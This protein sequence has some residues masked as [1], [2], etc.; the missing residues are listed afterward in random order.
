MSPGGTLQSQLGF[1]ARSV[2]IKNYTNQWVYEPSSGYYAEPYHTNIVIPLPGTQIA[3]LSFGLPPGL[4]QS[5]ASPKGIVLATWSSS[6]AAF[7]QGEAIQF[8]GTQP[9]SSGLLD[10]THPLNAPVLG[11]STAAMLFSGLTG[12]TFVFFAQ[13]SNDGVNWTFIDSFL[14]GQP[15]TRAD[16]VF[17]I[18]NNGIYIANVW[19]AAYF[20]VIQQ[21]TG[22]GQVSIFMLP[23]VLPFYDI[24]SDV[25]A[26]S[27][28]VVIASDQQSLP[29]HYSAGPSTSNVAGFVNAATVAGAWTNMGANFVLG[30][31]A[32]RGLYGLSYGFLNGA[33]AG[34]CGL[35]LQGGT[36]GTLYDLVTR[37]NSNGGNIGEDII[38][39]PA[40]DLIT[41]GFIN[42]E[43]IN[44]QYF[45][46]Q[47]NSTV[48]A[49]IELGSL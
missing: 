25:A 19:G 35:R 20:R 12:G 17:G 15:Y 8:E 9:V 4:A 48:W 5:T 47:A 38:Y 22:S 21:G 24:G 42:G 11:N 16:R 36:S 3:A 45:T 31:G 30:A 43:T 6:D 32:N 39:F 18:N 27:L 34:I 41:A 33:G 44:L 40:R 2:W 28:P 10:N 23:T 37:T 7:S 29:F 49:G 46:G 26:N 14:P 1:M 13:V